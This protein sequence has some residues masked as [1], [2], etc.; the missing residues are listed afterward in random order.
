MLTYG[1]VLLH[2][3]ARPHAAACT[4]AL[5]EH[6]SWEL[7]DHPSY[8]PDLTTSDYRL[9]NWLRLQRFSSKEELMEGVKTWL[10]SQVA[11]FFDTSLQ[12]TYSPI[13]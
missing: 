13:R 9:K 7:C 4:P 5:L 2:D 6:F 8:S 10:S 12:T 3:S 1:V 11:D